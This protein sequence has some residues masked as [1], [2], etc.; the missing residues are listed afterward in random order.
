MTVIR[1]RAGITRGMTALARWGP[2]ARARAAVDRGIT[3]GILVPLVRRWSRDATCQITSGRLLVLAP[4]PDDETLGCGA[5]IARTLLRGG[6]VLVVVATDGRSPLAH[7]DP[8]VMAA[9]RRGELACATEALG[10][11]P[12]QVLTL[13][14]PDRELTQQ[15]G[16]LIASLTALVRSWQPSIVLVTARRDPHPDHAALGKAARHVM[17]GQAGALFEYM[18]WGWMQPTRW[19]GLGAFG[20]PIGHGGAERVRRAAVVRTGRMLATKR[21]AMSC[22]RSQ[23]GPSANRVGLLAGHGALNGEFLAHFFGN[24]E[25]FFPVNAEAVSLA[26]FK[27]RASARSGRGESKEIP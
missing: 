26:G 19:L 1:A 22:H 15:Q 23:L 18:V 7:V 8:D 24:F 2:L 14:F 6:D 25:V 3:I 13:G 21:A 12:E 16:P 5:T 10:L 11:L 9:T 4:H 20:F 27:I 17:A